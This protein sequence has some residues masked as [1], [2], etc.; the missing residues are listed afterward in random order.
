VL[1]PSRELKG[2]SKVHLA[3]GE[4]TPVTIRLDG[5][6]FA[7]WH[8]DDARHA[9]LLARLPAPFLAPRSSA[10]LKPAGWRVDPGSYVLH[11]GRSSADI[12]WSLAVE[13]EEADLGT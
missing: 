6:S 4:C 5:R 13:V 9:D 12:A 2:F 3:P 11:V 8:S 1:R 10:F 7:H